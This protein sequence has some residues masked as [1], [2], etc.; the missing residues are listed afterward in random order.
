M[1]QPDIKLLEPTEKELPVVALSFDPEN[2][3]FLGVGEENE[4][5]VIRRLYE[6]ADVDEVIKSILSAGY[7]P[8]EPL[9][10]LEDGNVVLE[11]NRRLAAL[12]L[13]SDENLRSRLGVKLPIIENPHTP[14]ETVRVFRVHSRDDA[15]AYIGFK[16]INGPFKWDALAKAQY[17]ARWLATGGTLDQ[18]SKTLGDNH[19]TV[20]R[21]VRGWFTLEQARANGF[22]M[23]RISKRRFSFSHLYTALTRAPIRTFLGLSESDDSS[24]P[25]PNPVAPEHLD[26]LQILMSWLYGQEQRNEPTIIRSQ[27]PNLNQ[28]SK[29]LTNKEATDF[30]LADRDLD[31]AFN[32]VEPMS[33]RFHEILVS[34]TARSEEAL[35]LAGH[36]NGDVTPMRT[37]EN[38]QR[39]VR[40]LV[41][42]MRRAYEAELDPGSKK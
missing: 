13:I 29:V 34:A 41:D 28:L 39:T 20:E 24:H 36:Y 10:V 7:I 17:A 42:S 27:N 30:L 38:L 37:A 3:R 31:R 11:G 22:D 19:S 12:R 15:R 2:P 32:R 1:V 33:T 9:I 25:K 40:I 5:E 8:F 4:E 14:P 6:N 16:H 35:G 26:K 23:D 18:I 21:L